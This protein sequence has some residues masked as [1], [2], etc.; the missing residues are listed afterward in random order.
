MF[1]V[2]LLAVA[3]VT[4]GYLCSWTSMHEN[5]AKGLSAFGKVMATILYVFAAL[6]LI[7]GFT[8]GRRYGEM[9]QSMGHMG[10][11]HGTGMMQ[12]M[13]GEMNESEMMSDKE[14]MKEQMKKW[15]MSNPA[16]WKENVDELNKSEA[17]K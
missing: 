7:F 17:S 2:I 1:H 9:C 6:V 5:T 10:K 3:L 16:A 13:K 14:A 12:G 15:K 8:Y 4:L 11:M